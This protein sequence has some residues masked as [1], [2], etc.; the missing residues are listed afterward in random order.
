[1]T[2]RSA[3]RSFVCACTFVALAAGVAAQRG[4]RG[5]APSD[6]AAALRDVAERLAA[7]SRGGRGALLSPGTDSLGGPVVQNAP[8]SADAITTVIQVL[9]DGTRIEQRVT[10]RFYRDSTGRVR[11]EQTII[12]L[13]AEPQ[14]IVTVDPDPG[15]GSAYEL[16]VHARTARRV[17]LLG[18]FTLTATG[19]SLVLGGAG[20]RGL[21]IQGPRVPAGARPVE[22]SLGTRQMEGLKATGRKTTSTIP[23]G[24]IGNDRPIE[25]TDE[26]WDSPELRLTLMSR[27]HDPRTGDIEYRLANLSRAEPPPDLFVVPSDY[28]IVGPGQ[29]GGA[30]GGRGA[31]PR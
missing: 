24:Q 31:P 3:G 19:Q 28:T 23:A 6:P 13:T 25:I 27:H 1:M 15:D 26:R 4:G 20:G 16:D 5:D 17:A 9:G 29:R 22:E 30:R 8:Y 14:T 12:G 11:R 18:S 10:A 7:Q 2:L 21:W